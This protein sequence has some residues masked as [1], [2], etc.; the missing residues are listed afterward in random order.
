MPAALRYL[1]I[2]PFVALSTTA[3][4][5]A[6]SGTSAGTARLPGGATS[7]IGLPTVPNNSLPPLPSSTGSDVGATA[8]TPG[9]TPTTPASTAPIPG[10]GSATTSP[11]AATPGVI[12]QLPPPS[13]GLSSSP[14]ATR[15][16]PSGT[17]FC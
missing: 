14:G 11:Q 6:T 2:V 4:G 8:T 15:T 3:L 13:P 16:C 5:Q 7:S 12:I 10:L 17:T 9:L 1:W